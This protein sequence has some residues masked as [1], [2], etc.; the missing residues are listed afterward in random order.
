MHGL[1]EGKFA[2]VLDAQANTVGGLWNRLGESIAQGS[3]RILDAIMAA[4]GP[5]Y[6]L[7]S[8]VRAMLVDKHNKDVEVAI[9]QANA[10]VAVAAAGIPAPA[11]VAK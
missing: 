6:A 5:L 7:V 9:H 11:P 3:A 8:N 4:S 2:G 10:S 1:A